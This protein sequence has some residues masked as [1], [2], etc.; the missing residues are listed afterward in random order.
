MKKFIFNCIIGFVIVITLDFSLGKGLEYFYFKQSSGFQYRTTY[1]IEDTEDDI[2]V[3]G[4]SRANHHY[5]PSIIEE[6]IGMTC[7]NTG[8]D[9]NFIFY[10]TAVLK[11]VL[12]RYK[13]KLIL[14]DFTGDFSNNQEDYDRLSSLLPYY[15][16]HSEIRDIVNLRSSF[17][18]FKNLSGIYP[19]NSTLGNIV[20]GNLLIK[21]IDEYTNKGYVPL[22]GK[23]KEA[24]KENNSDE[25]YE[26]DP[27]KIKIFKE[28]LDL[29]K[30]NDIPVVV[31]VSPIFYKYESNFS[32]ELCKKKCKEAKVP[33]F[34]FTR[35]KDYLSAP[36]LFDDP[37][38]LN[39]EGA[40]IYSKDVVETIKYIL[41]K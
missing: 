41:N 29:C 39:D 31:L 6:E 8:R 4:S 7:Y 15:K 27:N 9:G 34:D 20:N 5:K 23:W 21:D 1:S 19:F 28:F 36:N 25:Q 32:I 2:L 10:Q 13:P 14:Y 3:F 24:L 12:E 16:N 37:D 35:N 33:F 30:Q 18:P 11:S 17:E 40:M 26:I 22:Y 38:H